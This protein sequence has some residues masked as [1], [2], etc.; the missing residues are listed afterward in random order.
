MSLE[1]STFEGVEPR[2]TGPFRVGSCFGSSSQLHRH[3]LVFLNLAA[4]EGLSSCNSH[5]CNNPTDF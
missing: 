1:Q 2:A 4:V 5:S 3:T